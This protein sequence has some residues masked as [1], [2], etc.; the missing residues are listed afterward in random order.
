MRENISEISGIKRMNRREL[1]YNPEF[2]EL[3]RKNPGI[4]KDAIAAFDEI[5]QNFSFLKSG[6]YNNDYEVEKNNIIAIS[7]GKPGSYLI[8]IGDS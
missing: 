6:E 8:K 4:V 7:T 3:I 5:D 1:Q 2:R